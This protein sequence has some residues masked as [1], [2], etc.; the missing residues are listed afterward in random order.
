MG[1]LFSILLVMPDEFAWSE[2]WT[3]QKDV[4]FSR[5]TTCNKV[6]KK[7]VKNKIVISKEGKYIKLPKAL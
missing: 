1:E 7:N 4:H 3:F 5:D 6:L 2:F